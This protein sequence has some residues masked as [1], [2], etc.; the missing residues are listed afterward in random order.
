MSGMKQILKFEEPTHDWQL[1]SIYIFGA[2]RL[3]QGCFLLD[4][5][6][7]Q[8]DVRREALKFAR[9]VRVETLTDEQFDEACAMLGYR[10]SEALEEATAPWIPLNA[11]PSGQVLWP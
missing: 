5:S 3:G 11:P 2:A 10:P 7:T 8:E 1:F 6:Q 9:Y 4:T